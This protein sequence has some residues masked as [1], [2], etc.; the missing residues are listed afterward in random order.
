M[1]SFCFELSSNA[2]KITS[3]SSWLNHVAV[4]RKLLPAAKSLAPHGQL[5]LVANRYL[6]YEAT[7]TALFSEVRGV[8]DEGG[9][10]VITARGVRA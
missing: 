2:P 1:G 9:F 5:W 3:Q 8:A 10:K 7:L 4:R 6:P